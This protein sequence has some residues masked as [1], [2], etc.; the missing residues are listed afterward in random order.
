VAGPLWLA[1]NCI[2]TPIG[3]NPVLREYAVVG[4]LLDPGNRNS[5]PM[6]DV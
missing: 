5:T 1:S 4:D 3:I 2:K 6:P